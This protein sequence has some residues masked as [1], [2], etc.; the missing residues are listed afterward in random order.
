MRYV[1]KR[2]KKISK[3]LKRIRYPDLF[4]PDTVLGQWLRTRQA[5]L[6]INDIL[7][8]HA[9]IHPRF[10]EEKMALSDINRIIRQHL[11][12]KSYVVAFNPIVSFMFGRN[13]VFWSRGYFKKKG[14]DPISREQLTEVLEFYNVSRVVVG[15]TRFDHVG[16][17]VGGLVL[18]TAV[19]TE[20]DKPAE[21]LMIKSGRFFNADARGNLLEIILK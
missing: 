13:G 8:V 3:K 2:Y 15:H 9:G 4:G 14:Y 5:V 12:A 17:H 7:Y 18:G 6:K 19:N 10:V 20:E 11:D 21:G 1:H 16:A